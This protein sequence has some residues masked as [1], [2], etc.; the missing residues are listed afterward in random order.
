M[1]L[2]PALQACPPR[3]D[4]GDA[5]EYAA[6]LDKALADEIATE[7][8]AADFFSSTYPTQAMRNACRMV[9]DRLKNGAAGGQPGVYR[10]S[11][12]YGGGKTHTLIALAAAARHPNLIRSAAQDLVPSDLAVDGVRI[13]SFNGR[14]SD[15]MTGVELDRSGVRAKSI[16]GFVAYRLGGAD[17]LAQIRQHDDRL[18]DPGADWFARLFSDKPTLI[19]VDELIH[20]V[21]RAIA[22]GVNPDT[23]HLTVAALAH[24]IDASPRTVLVITAPEQ[25][26]D[27]FKTDIRVQDVM[28][29]IAA[30]LA[31][32][33]HEMTPSSNED[34]AAILRQRIFQGCDDDA[35]AETSRAYAEIAKRLDPADLDAENRFARAYPFHPDLMRLIQNWLF[36]N[37]DF[38]R[39]RGAIRMMIDIV[40]GGK[41]GSAALL[42]PH[43]AD[44]SIPRLHDLLI[45]RLDFIGMAPAITADV[46]GERSVAG[47]IGTELAR[48]IAN[49]ILLASLAPDGVNGID[50]AKTVSAV[51]SPDHPDP[52]VARAAFAEYSNR[53]LFLDE[54]P[55][56][57]GER[58]TIQPNVRRMVNDRESRLSDDEINGAFREALRAEYDD[59]APGKVENPLPVVL[60]PSRLNNAPDLRDAV[61]LCIIAPDN[62]NWRDRAGNERIIGELHREKSG[63]TAANREHRNNVIFLVAQDNDLSDIRGHIATHMAASA[64]KKETPGLA[65][66]QKEILEEII[67]SQRKAVSQSIQ[68]KWTTLIYPS[69]R[70]GIGDAAPHLA[71]EKLTPATDSEGSGQKPVIA[72]LIERHKIPDPERPRLN[73]RVWTRTPL[74]VADYE[75]EGR[76]VAEIHRYFTGSPAR[77]M[78]LDRNAFRRVLIEAVRAQDLYMESPTGQFITA[79]NVDVGIE[80]DFRVWIH[81]KEPRCPNCAK[82]VNGGEPCPDCAKRPCPKCGAVMEGGACLKCA[83]P[84]G[85]PCPKCGEAM[86]GGACSKCA[87]P[88]PLGPIPPFTSQ[89]EKASVA[90]KALGSHMASHRAGRSDVSTLE[91]MS[92]R[93]DDLT[94]IADKMGVPLAAKA[95]LRIEV[96]ALDGSLSFELRD[97]TAE[98][99][100]ERE[101]T[102]DRIIGYS[103]DPDVDCRMTFARADCSPDDFAAVVNSFDNRRDIV[104]RAAFD[105][106]PPS[107]LAT[108][109]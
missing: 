70:N 2:A 8:G 24:A 17:A 6:N 37:G 12:V 34:L 81:G 27:A 101:R 104:L 88:P 59:S 106:Q 76:T 66:Y 42:H 18:A 102:V 103:Q 64:V 96:H 44:M 55:S 97:Q 54:S 41:I 84:P 25:G 63:A 49:T 62:F 19:L 90:A 48:R 10:F 95:A 65:P 35:R 82:R 98:Q 69:D 46:V 80:D 1:P 94:Y 38:Q 26:H 21:A 7:S 22:Q 71:V 40:S 51:L 4:L 68:A 45:T 14:N 11:S 92:T 28:A 79:D 15:A 77:M 109:R 107:G 23:I 99:W 32:V 20:H 31:R 83:V 16:A 100:K 85:E 72:K 30:E 29:R 52:A 43:H 78:M 86:E 93:P 74:G 3:P 56:R 39:V 5:Q 61:H 108:P 75:R 87:V 47:R 36:A 53:A 57:R 67:A 58:F 13:V 60:Y 73:R 9:F 50:E 91:I 89:P 105:R 33:S